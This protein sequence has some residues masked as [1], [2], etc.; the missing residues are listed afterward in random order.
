MASNYDWNTEATKSNFETT[1]TLRNYQEGRNR[2]E[3]THSKIFGN[4]GELNFG[5]YGQNIHFNNVIATGYDIVGIKGSEVENMRNAIRDYVS[6]VQKEM[7]TKLSTSLE[8]AR[9]AFRGDDVLSE[10]NKYIDKVKLY[11]QNVIS[12]L[13]VFSD[14]LADVGNAWQKAQQSMGGDISATTGAFSEGTAYSDDVQY[15]SGG[16]GSSAT[17]S[18]TFPS[19]YRTPT[20]NSMNNF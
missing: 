7:D 19:G 14:K 16:S 4:S 2:Y 1:N 15:S 13:L 10:L 6:N 11:C 18:G 5:G 17:P 20:N 8:E 3:S 12:G 9:K